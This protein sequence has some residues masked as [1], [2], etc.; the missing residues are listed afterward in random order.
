MGD[1]VRTDPEALR[2]F[3]KGTFEHFDRLYDISGRMY[4]VDLAPGTF[5]Y[6]PGI[7][8]RIF[9]SYSEFVAGLHESITAAGDLI[10]E[11]GNTV[12]DA[13]DGYELTD[14][15]VAVLHTTIYGTIEGTV[16]AGK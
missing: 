12:R 3:A 16:A 7:G 15:S 14:E 1:E 8:Q 5:G 6:I 9:D 2:A 10:S 13:A 11:L 4:V